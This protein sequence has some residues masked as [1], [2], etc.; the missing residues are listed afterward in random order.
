MDSSDGPATNPVGV[1]GYRVRNPAKSE[2]RRRAIL[3]GAA[4]AFVRRGYQA[5]S[6]EDIAAEAGLAKAHIYHYF[7]SKEHLFAEIMA[8][9]VADSVRQLEEIVAEGEGPT[10]TLRKAL[11]MQVAVAF[12]PLEQQANLLIYPEELSAENH[13][14]IRQLQRRFERL[15]QGILEDGI[16]Q[17]V[18]VDRNP[19]LMMLTLLRAAVGVAVWY[20]PD[21][22]WT[23]EWIVTEVAD[24]LL[25]SVVAP[26]AAAQA[27][28]TRSGTTAAG[29]GS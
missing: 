22:A 20:R 14:K 27:P 15:F 5:A 1:R 13:Q 9:S 4:R 16:A 11:E 12:R 19:K 24:Q 2:E 18:F 3:L 25:R 8:T 10:A 6:L 26:G 21:G 29:A 7:L 17:G 28:A 23:P